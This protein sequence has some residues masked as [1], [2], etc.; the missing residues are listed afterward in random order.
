MIIRMDNHPALFEIAKPSAPAR[1]R[2]DIKRDATCLWGLGRDGKQGKMRQAIVSATHR[3]DEIGP[4]G[5]P[6]FGFPTFTLP[7]AEI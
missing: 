1:D 6:S 4:A 5:L 3:D 7:C 2:G